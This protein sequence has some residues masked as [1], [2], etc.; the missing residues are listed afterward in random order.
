M[1]LELVEGFYE[2]QVYKGEDLII[3]LELGRLQ[4]KAQDILEG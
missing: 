2:D 1:I 4:L 3:S